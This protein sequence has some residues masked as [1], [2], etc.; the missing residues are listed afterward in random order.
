ML[1]FLYLAHAESLQ[2]TSGSAAQ[3]AARSTASAKRPAAAADV[4]P[5]DFMKVESKKLRSVL[6]E[7]M[8]YNEEE[9]SEQDDDGDD[10]EQRQTIAEA[11][12]DDD[13]MADF[14]KE[15]ADII[16]ASKPK[17]GILF[18]FFFSNKY[19][20]L[21]LISAVFFLRKREELKIDLIL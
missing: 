18:D 12:A 2:F 16:A 20:Y 21:N 8:G 15:K 11:F 13:V 4:N 3:K 17:V 1:N 14:R 5:D 10:D 19:G 6:P 7:I 9:N